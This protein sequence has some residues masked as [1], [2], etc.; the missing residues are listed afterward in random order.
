MREIS[1]MSYNVSDSD[2]VRARNQLK[3]SLLFAQDNPSGM[4]LL[5]PICPSFY[6]QTPKS[7]SPKCPHAFSLPRHHIL[8]NFPT[9][10]VTFSQA[11][12]EEEVFCHEHLAKSSYTARSLLECTDYALTH[13]SRV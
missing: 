2:I 8:G 11:I 4:G 13:C 12:A 3:A 10:P 1:R 9:G 5:A 6:L 7:T